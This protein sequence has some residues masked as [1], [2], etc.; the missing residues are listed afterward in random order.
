M[1]SWCSAALSFPCRALI[2]M[3]WKHNLETKKKPNP[4][5]SQDTRRDEK[6]QKVHSCFFLIGMSSTVACPLLVLPA[7]VFSP[8]LAD[9]SWV[10]WQQ[11]LMSG[12][13]LE[14]AQRL[15]NSG[16]SIQQNKNTGKIPGK[17]PGKTQ[18]NKGWCL[19]EEKIE[20]SVAK[21]KNSWRK[22]CDVSPT[23]VGRREQEVPLKICHLHRIYQTQTSGTEIKP[24][25]RWKIWGHY[26][27]LGVLVKRLWR[28]GYFKS[29][30][31][32]KNGIEAELLP[33]GNVPA[34][35]IGVVIPNPPLTDPFCW[36]PQLAFQRFCKHEPLKSFVYFGF[37]SPHL[38]SISS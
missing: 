3:K 15:L 10:E 28:I 4:R 19:V 9:R 30:H 12:N 16:G 13:A 20:I 26:W 17:I 38:E 32:V 22:C 23:T 27:C 31:F 34:T 1:E 7:G 24:R 5:F 14:A 8:A 33:M 35:K 18:L 25:R 21:I 37:I 36:K 11:F 6:G 2:W 29:F